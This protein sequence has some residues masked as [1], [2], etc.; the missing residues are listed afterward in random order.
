[1]L[2]TLSVSEM[3]LWPPTFLLI[4]FGTLGYEYEYDLPSLGDWRKGQY[5]ALIILGWYHDTRFCS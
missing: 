5:R 2:F 4:F 1:M 3:L